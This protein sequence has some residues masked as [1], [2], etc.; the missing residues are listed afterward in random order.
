MTD[1]HKALVEA[2][3]NKVRLRKLHG[4]TG[5][6][7][8]QEALQEKA[9]TAIEELSASAERYRRMAEHYFVTPERS[10]ADLHQEICV[11]CTLNIR[12]PVHKR[13]RLDG[14]DK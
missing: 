7:L 8:A 14:L 13:W 6:T 4:L 5:Q 12:D 10:N 11:K 1:D 2:L 9:V 3:R